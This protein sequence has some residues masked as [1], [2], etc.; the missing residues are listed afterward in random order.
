MHDYDNVPVIE[1]GTKH[2]ALKAKAQILHQE[3]VVL[4]MPADFNTD[5]NGDDYNCRLNE[6]TGVLHECNGAA[7]LNRLAAENNYPSLNTIAEA[8]MKSGSQVDIDTRS[9]RI[10]VH[11]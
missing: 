3:P 8:C 2:A 5:I 7:I 9:R 11:D 1:W 4:Q 6:N 10:I